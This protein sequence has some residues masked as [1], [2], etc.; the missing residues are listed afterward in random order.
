MEGTLLIS[1]TCTL[2]KDHAVVQCV[3]G[4][5]GPSCHSPCPQCACVGLPHSFV[6]VF[7]GKAYNHWLP[8]GKKSEVDAL[9]DV[10]A[11]QKM[12]ANE[13]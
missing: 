8:G 1:L 9:D 3:P 10:I 2:Y 12:A 4:G 6:T 7:L 11:E 13:G 5:I